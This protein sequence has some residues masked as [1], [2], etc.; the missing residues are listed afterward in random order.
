VTNEDTVYRESA[1]S[2][3]KYAINIPNT[4]YDDVLLNPGEIEMVKMSF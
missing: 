3:V 2:T 4:V 1:G